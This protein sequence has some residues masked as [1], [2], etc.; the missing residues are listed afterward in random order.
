MS[1]SLLDQGILVA[2]S[3]GIAILA[4]VVSA[5]LEQTYD[6][7]PT[8]LKW[9]D[10][11][12]KRWV[13]DTLRLLYA[14]IIPAIAL[15]L[16]GTLS[17]RGLGLKPFPWAPS[18]T[19]RQAFITAWQKDVEFTLMVLAVCW[20]ILTL[21]LRSVAGFRNYAK[22]GIPAAAL[23][24]IYESIIN[25]VHWAFYRALSIAIW[26]IASG[27]W[28]VVIPIVLELFLNPATWTRLKDQRGINV[29]IVNSGIFLCSTILFLQTQNLWVMLCLDF[30]L[31]MIFARVLMA[32]KRL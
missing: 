5:Y 16:Q 29:L 28:V 10:F 7:D 23:S 11:M 3:V 26:G 17:Y 30:V 27:S 1:T 13:I 20:I 6:R 25:Q 2:L 14:I 8:K 32:S 18:V 21:G 22:P 15:L 9:W 4:G 24:S 12:R 31:R 19:D